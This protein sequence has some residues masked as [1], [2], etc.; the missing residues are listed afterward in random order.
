MTTLK[1]L[2]LASALTLLAGGAAFADGMKSDGMMKSDHAQMQKCKAMGDKAKTNAKCM[3]MMKKMDAMKADPMKGDAM[4][5][6]PMKGDSM[7]AD[8][9]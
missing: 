2:A 6:D 3:A 5:A 7:K 1:T 9:H 8:H 4:K